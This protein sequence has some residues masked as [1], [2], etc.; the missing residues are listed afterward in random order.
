MESNV[1]EVSASG[2]AALASMRAEAD[3][4]SKTLASMSKKARRSSFRLWKLKEKVRTHV[5]TFVDQN[6]ISQRLLQ[7]SWRRP[8]AN[9]DGLFYEIVERFTQLDSMEVHSAVNCQRA[10]LC[11]SRC[12]VA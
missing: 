4:V 1:E 10:A 2:A 3:A 12:G 11:K 5:D 8:K 6:G 7:P 9:N